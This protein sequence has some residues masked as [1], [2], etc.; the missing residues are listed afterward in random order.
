MIWP[1]ELETSDVVLRR[2]SFIVCASYFGDMTPY[3]LLGVSL[4]NSCMD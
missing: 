3:V 2:E 4:R 1:E